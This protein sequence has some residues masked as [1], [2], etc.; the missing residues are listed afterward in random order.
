MYYTSFREMFV[1]LYNLICGCGIVKTNQNET[2][3]LTIGNKNSRF[4]L[5]LTYMRDIIYRS[6]I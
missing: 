4:A 1:C 6:D 5:V 3:T 2:A